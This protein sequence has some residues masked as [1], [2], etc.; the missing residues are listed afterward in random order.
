MFLAGRR[1]KSESK[2]PAPT[3][4]S[5]RRRTE[6]RRTERP[7]FYD[8]LDYVT[9]PSTRRVWQIFFTEFLVLM[10]YFNQS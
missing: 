2:A 9:P 3:V 5:K 8:S 10:K 6:R 4:T 1:T 7:S